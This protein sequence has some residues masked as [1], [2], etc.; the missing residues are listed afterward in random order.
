MSAPV[1]DVANHPDY[2]QVAGEWCRA[3]RRFDGQADSI[4]ETVADLPWAVSRAAGQVE[5]HREGGVVVG[6]H[7]AQGDR[8]MVG[9]C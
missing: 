4:A 2:A 9:C 7:S 5:C 6:M 8:S 1:L 3:L